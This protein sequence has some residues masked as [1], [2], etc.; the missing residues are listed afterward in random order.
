VLD[1]HGTSKYPNQSPSPESNQTGQ[2]SLLEHIQTS[3]EV[4]SQI[5]LESHAQTNRKVQHQIAPV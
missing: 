1:S 2:R 3:A 4:F 5:D